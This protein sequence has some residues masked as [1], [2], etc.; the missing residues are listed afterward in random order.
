M[1]YDVSDTTFPVKLYFEDQVFKGNWT[2]DVTSGVAT[3]HAGE[4]FYVWH[5][6]NGDT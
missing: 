3:G 4:F 1:E 6:E 5:D 2:M